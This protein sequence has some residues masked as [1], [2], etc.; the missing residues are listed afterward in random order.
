MN[1]HSTTFQIFRN[2]ISPYLPLQSAVYVHFFLSGLQLIL[3]NF[4]SWFQNS[5]LN[6]HRTERLTALINSL[7]HSLCN[8]SVRFF[9]SIWMI[10]IKLGF[11]FFERLLAISWIHW[12]FFKQLM[13]SFTQKAEYY[14]LESSKDGTTFGKVYNAKSIR[15]IGIFP[16][17]MVVIHC[18][19]G[20][21]VFLNYLISK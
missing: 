4:V 16:M 10:S 5:I 3:P 17:I 8:S 2:F 11:H 1:N 13:S 20:S 19:L 12:L 9:K 7:S 15:T 14:I 6:L 21:P 18:K